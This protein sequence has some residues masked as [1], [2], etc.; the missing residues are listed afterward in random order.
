MEQSAL[1][2]VVYKWKDE[3]RS[4]EEVSAVSE[5][6]KKTGKSGYLML[7]DPEDVLF[8][9]RSSNKSWLTLFYSLPQELVEKQ[10][11]YLSLPRCPYDVLRTDRYDALIDDDLFLQLVWDCYAWMVFQSIPIPRQDGTYRFI[12]GLD[13]HYSGDFPLW[14]FSYYMVGVIRDGFEMLGSSF[15]ALFKVKAGEEIP[16]MDY[17][18][19]ASLISDMTQMLIIKNNWQPMIDEIWNNRTPEPYESTASAALW[20]RASSII[21]R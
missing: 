8:I 5:E 1:F 12:P 2:C 20:R 11:E 7:N 16:F 3:Y 14:R 21:S 4:G 18:K 15:Q 9:P 17:E 10:K 6:T 19:W 13:L